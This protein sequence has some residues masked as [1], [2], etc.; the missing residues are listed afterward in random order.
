MPNT[1]NYV[2]ISNPVILGLSPDGN[3]GP[4]DT[5]HFVVNF[6]P[7]AAGCDTNSSDG[8]NYGFCNPGATVAFTLNGVA[9]SDPVSM[10]NQFDQYQPSYM[11]EYGGNGFVAQFTMD[12]PS[13]GTIHVVATSQNSID[14]GVITVSST[15]G[16][17]GSPGTFD[18]TEVYC[19][20]MPTAST[21]T[22]CA[23]NTGNSSELTVYFQVAPTAVG[24]GIAYYNVTVNGSTVLTNQVTSTTA[25]VGNQDIDSV[26]FTCPSAGS[27][28]V[29]QPANGS[30]ASI[31]LGSGSGTTTG[32][33]GTTTGGGGTTTGCSPTCTASYC[34]PTTSTTWGCSNGCAYNTGNPCQA[35][36]GGGTTTGGGGTT[37]GTTTDPISS[38]INS[39][40][41]FYNANPYVVY[42]AVGAIALVLVL[43]SKGRSRDYREV[44]AG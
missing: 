19:A 42:G 31:T 2:T 4:G 43:S 30:G 25:G 5:I 37:T 27:T 39:F 38:I 36:T 9:V 35:A 28:I 17:V 34:N 3:V 1:I 16:N 6:D 18:V 12:A 26:T 21:G 44:V 11:E 33:G 20:N 29:I 32:G 8:W 14:F 7:S 40:M 41:S 13:T 22:P 15:A 10:S 24:N 23:C